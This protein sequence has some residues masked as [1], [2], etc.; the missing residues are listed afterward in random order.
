MQL[1]WD[2]IYTKQKKTSSNC[3]TIV[4]IK[5]CQISYFF[6]F[7]AIYFNLNFDFSWFKL[8][9]SGLNRNFYFDRNGQQTYSKNDAWKTDI[10]PSL[11]E[12]LKVLIKTRL[13]RKFFNWKVFIMVLLNVISSEMFLN[14]FCKQFLNI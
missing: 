7:T 6:D 4:K 5:D 12:I 2:Q 3:K 8:L 14:N 10:L 11:A 1:T 9:I 13:F